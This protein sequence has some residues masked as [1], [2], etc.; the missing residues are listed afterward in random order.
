[1]S[2]DGR[3]N[4]PGGGAEDAEGGALPPRQVPEQFQGEEPGSGQLSGQVPE[5]AAGGASGQVPGQ[6]AGPEQASGHGPGQLSGQVPGQGGPGGLW[7]GAGWS[8]TPARGDQSTG[9]GG[10]GPSVP[11]QGTSGVRA[12]DAEDT[13]WADSVPGAGSPSG[14]TRTGGSGAGSESHAVP[15]QREGG[16]S[17]SVLPPPRDTPPSDADLIARMRSG[18]DGAYEELFRRHSEPV[19]RYAR[20]CCRDSH[21]ADDLTAE[22]FART[23]QAVRSGAGPEYAV[24]AYLMTTVRRV[25]ATWTNSAKR[26]QLVEDFALFATEAARSTEGS[27]DRTAE[28]GADVRA[29]HEAERSLAMQAFRSLPERWQAVL[30]HTTVE[31]ESPSEVAPLFGLTANATAVLASRAR[32]GLKQAYLQ[33]HVSSALTSGGDCA[34]YADRLGAYARGGLRMRAERGLRKHLEECAKCRLAAGEL[35]HVNA[36][37][38]ALLPVAVIGWFAAGYSLK[39]AGV[40]AGG[41]VGAAGAGAA[42]AA[43]GVGASGGAGAGAAGAAAGGAAASEG[44][45]APAK[46][47]IGAALAVA[48][49]AGLVWA[50]AGD[51]A[52]A[53]PAAKPSVARSVTPVPQDPKP[54]APKPEPAPVVPEPERPVPK[55][56]VKPKPKPEPVPSPSATP[57]KP[58]PKPPAATPPEP[59]P[60]PSKASPKPTPK[61]PAPPRDYQLNRLKYSVFGDGTGPEVAI[62]E[63]SWLWQRWGLRIGG[64]EYAHGV[65]VRSRSSVTINLNRPCTTYSAMAGVDDLTLGRGAMTF[66]VYADGALLWRSPVLRGGEPAVPVQVPLDGRKKLRLVVEPYSHWDGAALG[67]WAAS[68]IVCR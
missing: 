11:A 43:T 19:R 67:D 37:I 40:V 50:F 12:D 5:Q 60:S 51:P 68:K 24:R 13:G 21:T 8:G 30:W 56:A 20:T 3:G 61:P 31:E 35:K 53:K 66:S 63:S 49:A 14:T 33:A 59:R 58:R 18:D 22:V 2:G 17:G 26:E 10:A 16:V 7:P 39:A 6:G 48:T 62:G 1:M 54:P 57:P 4:A 64:Q 32:E 28:L 36:G 23:L 15:S 38:P 45:G 65:T 52:P 27:P 42:A 25:A 41:A 47:G 34:R 29:M 9:A 55:P 44:L 46:V